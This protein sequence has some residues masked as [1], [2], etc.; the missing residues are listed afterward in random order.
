MDNTG[1]KKKKYPSINGY[2]I[3]GALGRTKTTISFRA[4]S[5]LQ[6]GNVRIVLA[7]GEAY[8]TSLKRHLDESFSDITRALMFVEH[9][10][11]LPLLDSGVAQN[12]PF[13]VSA[14]HGEGS[15]QQFVGSKRAWRDVFS[16]L[17][18]IADALAYCHDHEIIHRDVKPGNIVINDQGDLCLTNFCV[19]PPTIANKL[20]VTMTGSGDCSPA[21]IAPEIWQGEYTAAIDQYSFGVMMYELLTGRVP[22][23]ATNIVSLL[24][25]QA[26]EKVPA[27][28]SLAPG[29]PK[30]VDA[31]VEKMLESDPTERFGSMRD[32]RNVMQELLNNPSLTKQAVSEFTTPAKSQPEKTADVTK[33]KS[34]ADPP[35]AETVK[36]KKPAAV[37]L[38]K[39]ADLNQNQEKKKSA[40]PLIIMFGLLAVIALSS[41]IFLIGLLTDVP[42]FTQMANLLESRISWRTAGDTQDDEASNDKP[43]SEVVNPSIGEPISKYTLLV[44]EV[45]AAV[46]DSYY[47]SRS[48]GARPTF[49]GSGM[50]APEN[51]QAGM[52]LNFPVNLVTPERLGIK[53][54][55]Y[56]SGNQPIVGVH[57]YKS[58]KVLFIEAD[59]YHIHVES[60]AVFAKTLREPIHI[61]TP[62]MPNEVITL[63]SGQIL[64]EVIGNEAKVWCLVGVCQI[65]S[66]NTSVST[67][68][69]LSQ[70]V[71]IQE[72]EG[73]WQTSNTSI[74][75]LI[76]QLQ[77]F[78]H[79]CNKCMD[80][81]ALYE[82]E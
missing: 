20:S 53:L 8:R 77:P 4:A 10:N 75:G 45:G 33:K 2:Q 61:T 11:V 5:E 43:G 76:D 40:I 26:A 15:L 17:L 71:Y 27:P 46:N 51:A 67:I 29:V 35:A 21:Y 58:S 18:P 55:I 69:A 32:V 37:K 73:F 64:V 36:V 47:V 7:N 80:V 62:I 9:P 74:F 79:E 70:S 1:E 41:I 65:M 50:D 19:L 23:D 42:M 48:G 44:S 63:K 68:R 49:S 31:L 52:E 28:S 22:F 78:Y 12:Y 13:T 38:R 30:V 34:I 81:K 14:Y 39:K 54:V 3:E 66:N 72:N 16:I 24:V 25:Q 56:Q 60:G 59:D 6:P 57:V 82:N